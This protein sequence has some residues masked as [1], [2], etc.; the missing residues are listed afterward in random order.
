[1]GVG[2]EVENLLPPCTAA[3]PAGT[4]VRGYIQAIAAGD[5]PAA[6]ELI[7]ARNPFPSVCAWICP[8]PC[9]DSCR[10]GAVDEP[11]AI[12]GLKRFAVEVCGAQWRPERVKRPSGKSVAV[13]G[14]G[15]AGLT[16]AYRLAGEGHRVDVFERREA[17]GGQLWA[18]V[19][20]FR[21]PREVLRRDIE[22][23][24][25]AGVKIN[26]GVEIGTDITLDFLEKKYDA[27]VLSTGLWA[28]RLPAMAGGSSE[29]VYTALDF[30]GLANRGQVP[31]GCDRVVVVGGGDVAMDAA[32][33]ALRL[34]AERVLVV[35]LEGRDEMPA[36]PVEVTGA[37]TEGA[38]L[39]TGYG[40][41]KVIV[42]AG[43]VTGLIVQKVKYVFDREGRFNPIF[44]A[45]RLKTLT[46]DTVVLATGQ[47]PEAG[48][49]RASGL[50]VD[51]RGYP[52]LWGHKAAG[53]A[54]T[55]VC[56]EL[57]CGPGAAVAAVASGQ[58]AAAEVL[59]FLAGTSPPYMPREIK[60]VGPLPPDVASSVPRRQRVEPPVLPPAERVKTF[61]PYERG[62]GE[63]EA[64]LEASRCLQ[65]GMGAEVDAAKCVACL[66]CVRLCPY[67][68]PA[69]KER[70]H[71]P[72]ESC[73]ACGTCAAACPAK[74][75]TM[76]SLDSS[77]LQEALDSVLLKGA[78][79]VF[80]CRD[81]CFKPLNWYPQGPGGVRVHFVCLPSA[82]SLHPEWILRAFEGGA[83]AVVVLACGPD[84]R[85]G[86]NGKFLSKAIGRIK[87]LLAQ[88]GLPPESIALMEARSGEKASVLLESYLRSLQLK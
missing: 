44:E 9:E 14:A 78:V 17:P 63:E 68:V 13:V 56:G 52:R 11:L 66:T 85:C 2:T 29:G 45:G 64:F 24:A 65:C 77:V 37:L 81:L 54:R 62:L 80:A 20:V 79:V 84:C 75:I 1:M 15:P 34:G 8:H 51:E 30:L 41:V 12:R 49:L 5:Y 88:A 59:S 22:K 35:C 83:L 86:G 39:L 19:P 71:I 58:R 10:R 67:G 4:D 55:F 70:A 74:A 32:R 60:T 27:V 21:L 40:P 31:A 42:D 53:A 57:A 25:A 87:K 69:V 18:S 38:E 61:L 6:F 43:K 26:C 36:N 7:R 50:E 73:Q 28:P 76:R 82:A 16:A 33:T 72:A 3:C 48:F 23:I 47:G 46:C